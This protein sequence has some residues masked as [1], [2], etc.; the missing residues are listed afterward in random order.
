[1]NMTSKQL[2]RSTSVLPWL[3]YVS[4]IQY[5][6]IQ[7]I[8]GIQF[9]PRYSLANNTISDLGNTVC[10]TYGSR[11]VCSPLHPL[12]NVSFVVVGLTILLGSFFAYKALTKSRAT[13]I[14]FCMFG[15]GGLGTILVGLFPE[16]T[17]AILH[18]LGAFLP[19]V[20]GNAGL[21]VL[22]LS[23][24]LPKVLKYYTLLTGI[25][26]LSALVLFATHIY[27][28]VG[29][30]GMERVVAYPQTIWMIALGIYGL[31]HSRH[32]AKNT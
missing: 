17:V 1:M 16:N 19:F 24:P 15:V 13:L 8:V 10:G 12:M 18:V 20:I 22:G 6:I 23:L 7:L 2:S 32:R 21:I 27:L 29:L 14:G 4:S 28:G 31:T 30:G 9:S 5:F 3:L 26:A 25:F 11:A